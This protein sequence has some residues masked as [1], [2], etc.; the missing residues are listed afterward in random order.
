MFLIKKLLIALICSIFFFVRCTNNNNH[1]LLP[2]KTFFKKITY[3]TGSCFGECPITAGYIDDS[4]NFYYFGG[5]YS[6]EDS[7]PSGYYKGKMPD[8]IWYLANSKSENLK[9]Y[10]DS[11]WEVNV[12]GWP[13][14]IN[15]KDTLGINKKI[16]GEP[17]NMPDSIYAFVAW[18]QGLSRTLKLEKINDTI[19]FEKTN[20]KKE[21]FRIPPPPKLLKLPPINI[22]KF[23]PPK[24]KRT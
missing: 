12:D 16:A 17:G 14:E 4:L 21:G 5:R 3:T 7:L 8:T 19:F 23:M 6:E 10:F 9:K 2:K 24:N 22:L 15:L 11:T 1:I 13:I 18:L 20:I